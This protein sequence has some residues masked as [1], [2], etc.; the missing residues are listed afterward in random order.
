MLQKMLFL[1]AL[2]FTFNIS[3]ASP[4]WK[5]SN[6]NQHTYIGGTFHILSPDDYPLPTAFDRAYADSSILVFET[7]I[8]KTNSQ[9]VQLAMVNA[10]TYSDDRTLAGQLKP[11]TT[12]KLDV[13]LQSRGMTV[14]NFAKFTPTGVCLTLAVMEYQRLGMVKEYGVDFVFNNK[15]KQDQ[16]Q[17]IPLE[18][19][20]EQIKFISEIG[21]GQE[22]EIVFYT[23]KEINNLP[24]MISSL[25]E[26]WASGNI[27]QLE[28][29][30]LNDMRTQFPHAFK[31]IIVDRNNAWMAKIDSMINNPKTEFILVG[32]LHLAG[33]EGLIHLLKAKSYTVEH[34]N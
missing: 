14:N 4:V 26:A 28:E 19:V 33:K 18:S 25:K 15:A 5:V 12:A 24:K 10:L 16:K 7:D 3:A 20:A 31:S 13:F 21:H 32:A 11:E 22:N 2:F 34:L 1:V 6:G 9:E 29:L 17:V 27:K 30:A 8:D 23:L